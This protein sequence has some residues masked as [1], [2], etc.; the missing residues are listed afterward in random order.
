MLAIVAQ[1]CKWRQNTS[2]ESPLLP[3]QQVIGL[4]RKDSLV[5]LQEENNLLAGVVQELAIV[6]RISPEERGT[7]PDVENEDDLPTVARAK[8]H[9]YVAGVE[10][11]RVADD[12]EVSD[13]VEVIL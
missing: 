8:L 3:Y 6:Q 2:T 13:F 4:G 10:R 7:V 9:A 12:L 1:L 5:T 11:V